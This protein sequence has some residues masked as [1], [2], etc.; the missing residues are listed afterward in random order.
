MSKRASRKR[1]EDHRNDWKPIL[2]SDGPK[3][4]QICGASEPLEIEAAAADE[5]GPKK[6]TMVAYTGGAMKVGYGWPVVIDLAGIKVPS[7]TTPIFR[8]HDTGLIVGHTTKVDVSAQRIKVAGVMSGE[9]DVVD[10]IV[11]TSNRGF[12]W[13]ASVGCDVGRME[14]VDRDE[15]VK[16]NGRSFTGPVYVARATVLGE[17]S[18]VPLGA[19]MATSATVAASKSGETAMNPFEKWLA[20]KGF[21]PAALTDTQKTALE[22]AF[23]AESNPAPKPADKP[24]DPAIEA[25]YDPNTD[26]F[27]V[28]RRDAQSADLNRSREISRICASYEHPEIKITVNGEEV[29][30]SLEAHAIKNGWDAGKVEV[31]A[32][33]A[34][35]AKYTDGVGVKKRRDNAPVPG[36][37]IEAALCMSRGLPN[38]EKS[39]KPEV[40]EA[41]H[42]NFRNLGVQQLILMAAHANGFSVGP[43]F[44]ISNGNVRE[45]MKAAFGF[46]IQ[47]ASGFSTMSLPGI[48]GAVAN[49]DILAGYEEEDDSWREVS[50]TKNVSNFQQ[51]TSYRM[52]DD[53]IYEK[54][55]AN[56]EI[57]HGS[58]AQESYTRQADTYAKMFVL[59]RKDIINDDMGAFDDLRN[60]LGRGSKKAFNN[61][62]WTEWLSNASTFW[63]TART[64]YIE[65][66]TT[67]LGVDGVGLGLGVKAFRQM[68]SPAAD[69]RKRVGG[70]PEILLVPP[71]LEQIADAL[72]IAGNSTNVKVSDANTHAG[73]YRPVVNSWLSDPAFTGYSTTAWYLLRPPTSG[74]AVVVSFLNGMQTPTVESAEADFNTLGVQFRGYHDFGIDQA[75]YLAGIKSKG[76]A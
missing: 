63:T 24:A 38:I 37:V 68:T 66:A 6:F 10:P 17:I 15:Q 45:V 8:D 52:L 14:F 76:A 44:R 50:V 1:R 23:K 36:E 59:T 20:A 69:G 27:V 56:G 9:P 73:K 30:V 40:L 51:H 70:R 21:D 54:L 42:K 13:Q 53:M 18:F 41:A 32:L 29:V 71:E 7:Q 43:G 22:A 26:P 47:A 62:F 67:N 72:Y 55:P 58:L 34:E 57:K 35:R 74:S 5:S 28:A 39:F 31:M 48:L 11:G 75:E 61:A 65:G 60:R 46:G 12:P 4:F 19:D 2:A 33:R 25:A 64:N 49:K 3:K 16:V